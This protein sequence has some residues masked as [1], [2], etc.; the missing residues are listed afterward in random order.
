[1]SLSL[2]LLSPFH[3]YVYDVHLAPNIRGTP[4]FVFVCDICVR[5]VCVCDSNQKPKLLRWQTNRQQTRRQR[6]KQNARIA[7]ASFHK[8]GK[9]KRRQR[10]TPSVFF[11][12]FVL[13]KL[14]TKLTNIRCTVFMWTASLLSLSLSLSL[15]LSL[16][17]SRAFAFAIV[18]L[19]CLSVFVARLLKSQLAPF[20]ICVLSKLKTVKTVNVAFLYVFGHRHK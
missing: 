19:F 3:F 6:S 10:Q 16:Q 5:F 1:V 4:V 13:A 18:V 20:L 17:H 14:T 11:P 15:F 9:T 8:P 12:F 7:K 2:S